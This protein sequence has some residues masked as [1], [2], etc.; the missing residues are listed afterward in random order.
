MRKVVLYILLFLLPILIIVLV[1]ETS[2]YTR[3]ESV[4]KVKD[5]VAI[6]SDSKLIDKC[7]WACYYSTKSHCKTNHTNF[8]KPYFKYIDPLYFGI[9]DFMH[10]GNNYKLMNVLFLVFLIPVLMYALLVANIELYL[11]IKRIKKANG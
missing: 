1:N 9:I 3:T 10:K 4:A 6:N 8:T 2:R 11:R 7:T 5:V